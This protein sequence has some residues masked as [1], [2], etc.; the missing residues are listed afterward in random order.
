MIVIDDKEGEK[1]EAFFPKGRESSLS[2]VSWKT[3]F[4]IFSIPSKFP[5]EGNTGNPFVRKR[6]KSW[7]AVTVSASPWTLLY[8]PCSRLLQPTALLSSG[9]AHTG[10]RPPALRHA[11]WEGRK[12]TWQNETPM[13]VD[14]RF[15]TPAPDGSRLWRKL[16]KVTTRLCAS[17]FSLAQPSELC[18]SSLPYYLVSKLGFLKIFIWLCWVLVVA[19]G[20]LV[21]VT[22]PPGKSPN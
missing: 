15:G 9:H 12:C 6:K 14:G 18:L 16:S 10:V 3:W 17:P 22:R 11:S 5:L 2:L 8:F 7:Q 4:H 13:M 19:C 20:T 1:Q 21:L